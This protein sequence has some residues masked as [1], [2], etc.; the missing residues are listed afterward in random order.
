MK[1]Y[2]CVNPT[3]KIN[4]I[5]EPFTTM[6]CVAEDSIGASR[7]H[8]CRF[9]PAN[10]WTKEILLRDYIQEYDFVKEYKTKF[11][12]DNKRILP[13]SLEIWC[14]PKYV[15]VTELGIYTGT[16]TVPFVVVAHKAILG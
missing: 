2:K 16:S 8:P 9:Q 7:M 3:A 14:L 1:I 5:K 11:K 13:E 12:D 4:W 6:V 15:Q 10:W